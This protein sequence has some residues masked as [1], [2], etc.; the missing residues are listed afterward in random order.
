MNE[1]K[2]R[3]R[4]GIFALVVAVLALVLAAYGVFRP[5]SPRPSASPAS[6]ESPLLGRLDR[7]NVI[8]AGYG[9]YPPYTQ[10]DPKTGKVSGV[11][12]DIVEE[13]A[14]EIG[15]K[16]EWRRLNWNTMAADLK[17]GEFDVVADPIF[18]TPQRA[19]ELTFTEPYSYFPIGIG[20]VRRGDRRFASF[21]AINTASVTAA[22]GQ[23]TGEEAL[24]KARAPKAKLL[25]VPIG[26]DSAAPINSVLTGRADI[27]ISNIEDAKRFTGAHAGQLDMLWADTPPAYAP[28]GFALRFGDTAGAQFL[29]VAIRNMKGSGVLKRIAG[30]HDVTTNFDDPEKR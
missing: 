2:V 20:I 29:N 13:L 25:S 5:S 11:S 28:A 18:Q 12:V 14:R 10:E 24:V 26:Q 1:A 23:G 9:V 21:D 16:V 30:Q 7:T 17:R 8:R 4:L 15:A 27:A 3:N 19:R 22:V 6:S